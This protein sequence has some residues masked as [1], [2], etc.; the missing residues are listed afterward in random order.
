MRHFYD[1]HQ[2]S[3]MVLDELHAAIHYFVVRIISDFCLL[4]KAAWHRR[5]WELSSAGVDCKL[6]LPPVCR[7]LKKLVNLIITSQPWS[8]RLSGALVATCLQTCLRPQGCL[9]ANLKL[10]RL[11]Q[12]AFER[13]TWFAITASCCY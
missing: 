2:Q 1:R 9:A 4:G 3:I 13:I 8:L 6:L 11:C 5:V 7:Q 10:I 12:E